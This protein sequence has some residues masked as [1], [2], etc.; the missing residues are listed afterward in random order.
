MIDDALRCLKPGGIAIFIE[1]DFDLFSE[2]QVTIEEPAS[3]T[4][5]DGSWLCRWMNGA[6]V[7]ANWNGD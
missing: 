2:S 4:N 7:A 3:E 6:F 5:P 1:G